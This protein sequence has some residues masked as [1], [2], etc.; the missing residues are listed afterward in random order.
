MEA[1][2]HPLCQPGN[3]VTIEHPVAVGVQFVELLLCPNQQPINHV[4]LADIPAIHGY[5]FIFL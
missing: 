3:L 5:V 4:L 1:R 2:P